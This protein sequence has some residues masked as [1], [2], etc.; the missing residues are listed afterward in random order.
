[1]PFCLSAS[2]I[3]GD[4]QPEVLCSPSGLT[5]RPFGASVSGAPGHSSAWKWRGRVLPALSHPRR[6]PPPAADDAGRGGRL[7][8]LT[9]LVPH[10]RTLPSDARESRTHTRTR[11]QAD[12]LGAKTCR[13][14]SHLDVDRNLSSGLVAENEAAD[15]QRKF[16]RSALPPLPRIYRRRHCPWIAPEG[17]ILSPSLP[18]H[19][20]FQPR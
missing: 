14:I 17:R 11:D 3:S 13:T 20:P 16:G 18:R 1:M 5:L 7:V 19:R 15:S 10:L 6:C 4:D 8:K 12:S 9:H 2:L